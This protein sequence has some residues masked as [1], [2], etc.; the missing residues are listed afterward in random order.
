MADHCGNGTTC[1]SYNPSG[2]ILTLELNT[3][4]VKPNGSLSLEITE[5]NPAPYDINISASN[6]WY[7]PSLND[8]PCNAGAIP[9]GFEIFRGYYSLGNL[10]S[11]ENVIEFAQD[12]FPH[13]CF[14][15]GNPNSFTIPAAS[16]NLNLIGFYQVYAIN[17]SSMA[18]N[19]Y[20]YKWTVN[21]LGSSQP[22]V[23][24]I[25]VGDEWGDV[26]VLNFSVIAGTP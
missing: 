22:A 8:L 21:S 9:F 23:Y 24:T 11:G 6:R 18:N 12:Q 10:S 15:N 16:L 19:I 25:V 14:N 17:G 4:S 3:T 1:S 13:G 20:P 5:F 7:L 26:A 2:F